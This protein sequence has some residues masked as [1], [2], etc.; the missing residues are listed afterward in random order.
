MPRRFSIIIVHR[1]G[2]AMPLKAYAACKTARD[3]IFIVDVGGN[4]GTPVPVAT[5]PHVRPIRNLLP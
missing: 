5:F 4:A 2:A 3:Q 1:N